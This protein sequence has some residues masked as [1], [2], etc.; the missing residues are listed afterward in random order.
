MEEIGQAEDSEDHPLQLS[1]ALE[2]VDHELGTVKRSSTEHGGRFRCLLSLAFFNARYTK[3]SADSPLWNFLLSW[4]FNK[5]IAISRISY[6][7]KYGGAMPVFK[8]RQLINH[9]IIK[10]LRL[11]NRTSTH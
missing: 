2:P 11:I 4:Y 10:Y 6:I 3:P 1:F 7:L 9:R 5:E 8:K